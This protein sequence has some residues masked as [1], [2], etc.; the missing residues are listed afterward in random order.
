M[1]V[2]CLNYA[3]THQ[4]DLNENNQIDYDIV[5]KTTPSYPDWVKFNDGYQDIR[6]NRDYYQHHNQHYNQHYNITSIVM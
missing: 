6:H 5:R 4:A 3:L 2:T 1:P